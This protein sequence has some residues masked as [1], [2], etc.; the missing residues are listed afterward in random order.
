MFGCAIG[1]KAQAII[2]ALL[3]GMMGIQT[4][5][6][7]NQTLVTY[8]KMIS[9]AGLKILSVWIGLFILINPFI[10]HPKGWAAFMYRFSENMSMGNKSVH[11]YLALLVIP[12]FYAAIIALKQTRPSLKQILY[13]SATLIMYLFMLNEG[14]LN[15]KYN[16]C[17]M[18]VLMISIVWLLKSL[19]LRMQIT[20]AVTLLSITILV[21]GLQIVSTIEHR[22][23]D[24]NTKKLSQL[25]QITAVV[26]EDITSSDHILM[27]SGLP[28]DFIQLN[29]P[30]THLHFI[31]GGLFTYRI[32]PEAFNQ[33]WQTFDVK[34]NPNIKSF[35]RK[36][37]L[38]SIK[39]IKCF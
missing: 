1:V 20:I 16:M 33:Q 34:H 17:L 15:S 12:L 23:S 35:Y 32:D 31:M 36:N 39:K 25:K 7:A 9:R 4:W 8:T 13:L 24:E 10:C 27:N 26:S 2:Y 14:L 3:L 11:I 37:I 5:K 19:S 6:E 21:N 22:I 28:L 38:S 18:F 30:M 29:V